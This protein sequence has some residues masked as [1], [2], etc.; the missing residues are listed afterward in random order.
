MKY[1]LLII[2]CLLATSCEE[3]VNPN[4][5]TKVTGDGVT[6]LVAQK[7]VLDTQKVQT[8]NQNEIII[9]L[10]THPHTIIDSITPIIQG[11]GW[12]IGYIVI[13]RE[14]KSV[15]EK[16]NR[17]IALEKLTEADKIALGLK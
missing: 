8:V 13:Y 16:T 5:I 11:N 2:L 12:C 14:T 4:Q 17:E 6:V 3:T 7:I 15:V 9:W 1:L 10:K